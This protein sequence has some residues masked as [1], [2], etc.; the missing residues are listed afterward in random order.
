ME[1]MRR[2][3]RSSLIDTPLEDHRAEDQ[4]CE[5]LAIGGPRF[6]LARGN[7]GHHLKGALLDRRGEDGVRPVDIA[8]RLGIGRVSVY[9]VLAA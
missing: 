2:R 7:V 1:I 5:V 8:R 9:R 6:Q 3:C 4:A